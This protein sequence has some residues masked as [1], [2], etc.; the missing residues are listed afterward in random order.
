MICDFSNRSLSVPSDKLP[1]ISGIARRYQERTGYRYLAG[2]WEEE[3]VSGLGW[4][5]VGEKPEGTVQPREWRAPTWSWACGEGHSTYFS[6]AVGFEASI[7]L[8]GSDVRPRDEESPFGEVREG[9]SITVRG[10]MVEAGVEEEVVRLGDGMEGI[11]CMDWRVDASNGDG[12]GDV[13]CFVWD[14][15]LM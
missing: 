15:V 7:E 13:F 2:L 12:D 11:A 14:W 6:S 1:A 3:F 10:P 8:V 5:C 4:R 9:A